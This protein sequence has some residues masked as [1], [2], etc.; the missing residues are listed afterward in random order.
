ME[1]SAV[2][3]SKDVDFGAKMVGTGTAD[4]SKLSMGSKGI[5]ERSEVSRAKDIDFGAKSGKN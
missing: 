5:M 3:R 4:V 2:D 1:R